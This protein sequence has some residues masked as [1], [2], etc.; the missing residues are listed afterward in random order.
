MLQ[1]SLEDQLA[2]LNRALMKA[3]ADLAEFTTPLDAEK[4]DLVEAEKSLSASVESHAARKSS[5]VQGASE[6]EAPVKV[7]VE[8]VKSVGWPMRRMCS[9]RRRELRGSSGSETST[10]L[11]G[12]VVVTVVR[13]LA[14]EEHSSSLPHLA[15][16][17]SATL[18]FGAGTGVDPL[19][20]VK[21][22]ITELISRLQ[23]EAAS[24][25]SQNAVQP[26]RVRF[27]RVASE[28]MF[29][30]LHPE[31]GV[32]IHVE[33]GIAAAVLICIFTSTYE[34][35]QMEYGHTGNFLLIWCERVCWRWSMLRGNL[36]T[37]CSL[38]W[39]WVSIHLPRRTS[40]T[41]RCGWRL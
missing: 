9:N 36:G 33:R 5:S 29:Q 17:I 25:A 41:R 23:E 15:S 28:I 39:V 2:Q 26:V 11:A 40:T 22:L 24:E 38:L 32:S 35:L 34:V 16:R 1:Q 7:F 27:N 18:K 12:S 31:T 21:G 6:H 4:A 8:E 19:A 13:R 3:N 37:Q 14:K 10:H 20:K 30:P